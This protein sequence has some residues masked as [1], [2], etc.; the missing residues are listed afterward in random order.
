VTRGLVSPSRLVLV[1]AELERRGK[2]QVE[3]LPDEAVAHRLRAPR[4]PV[5]L[6]GAVYTARQGRAAA[7]ERGCPR[8]P[9]V[10]TARQGRAAA[11]ERGCPRMPVVGDSRRATMVR[12][13]VGL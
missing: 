10:Y 2:P 9:A 13:L 6:R 4:E 12:L 11:L 5:R 1:V 3:R 8:M 7:L